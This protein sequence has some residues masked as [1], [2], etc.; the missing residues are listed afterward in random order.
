VTRDD[1]GMALLAAHLQRRAAY[2]W[3]SGRIQDRGE[4]RYIHSCTALHEPSHSVVLFTRDT[5]HHTSGW[6]KNPDFERCLHLSLS[7]RV[8]EDRRLH[9][10]PQDRKTSA[11]WARLFFG[12]ALSLAWVESPK[13]DHGKR[14]DVWH[15]RVFCDPSWAPMHPRGEVYSTELTEIGWRS[16]SQVLEEDGIE[17]SSVLVPG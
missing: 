6:M 14:H 4:A 12:D 5:G 15:W 13:S 16:A 3:T 10:L 8:V 7:Y 2:G 1:A 11:H 9:L 17:V